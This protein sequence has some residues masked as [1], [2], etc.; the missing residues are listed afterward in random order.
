MASECCSLTKPVISSLV[1]SIHKRPATTNSNFTFPV[2][3][4]R[5]MLDWVRTSEERISVSRDAL[6]IEQSGKIKQKSFILAQLMFSVMNLSL[7]RDFVLF[8]TA[9]TLLWL[10]SSSIETLLLFCP[11]R[12]NTMKYESGL[13]WNTFCCHKMAPLAGRTVF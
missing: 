4:W 2:K 11:S 3:G 5:G 9:M 7:S 12:G 8:Q 6:S 13:P 10:A 1:L